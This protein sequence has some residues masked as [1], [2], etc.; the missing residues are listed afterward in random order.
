MRRVKAGGVLWCTFLYTMAM[1]SLL[2]FIQIK[3]YAIVY[4]F[5]DE[6]RGLE[7]VKVV[8]CLIVNDVQ[9]GLSVQRKKVNRLHDLQLL[10]RI[11]LRAGVV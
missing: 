11:F 2:S 6:L 9:D 5:N 8:L 3:L 4:I 10:G 7:T 1:V